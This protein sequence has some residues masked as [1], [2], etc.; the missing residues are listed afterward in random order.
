M[1]THATAVP[2]SVGDCDVD[3][4]APPSRDVQDQTAGTMAEGRL[5][6]ICQRS[7]QQ[8]AAERHMGSS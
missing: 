1:R 2:R 3:G 8:S 5:G 7:R 6:S 4:T